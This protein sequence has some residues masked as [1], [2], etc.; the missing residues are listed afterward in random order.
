MSRHA[1]VLVQANTWTI[2]TNPADASPTSIRL[3]NL[4][5]HP[6]RVQAKNG[7]D[8]IGLSVPGSLLLKAGGEMIFSTDTVASLF[9]GLTTPNHLFAWSIFPTEISVSHA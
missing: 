5:N 3:Q 9:P 1:D 2:L 7:P 8:N 4:G 6:V